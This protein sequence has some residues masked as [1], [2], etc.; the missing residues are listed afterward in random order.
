M[1]A[2]GGAAPAPLF[3]PGVEIG[4]SQCTLFHRALSCQLEGSRAHSLRTPR[5]SFHPEK[6]AFSESWSCDAA[7]LHMCCREN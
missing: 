7:G 4:R 2:K 6:R 5:V 1:G 3:I